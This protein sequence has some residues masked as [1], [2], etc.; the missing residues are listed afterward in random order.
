MKKEFPLRELPEVALELYAR[1]ETFRKYNVS[2]D[3]AV[4]CYNKMKTDTLPVEYELIKEEIEDI[5]HQLVHAEKT[6][7]WNSD[8]KLSAT[9]KFWVM[10]EGRVDLSWGK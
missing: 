4:T 3:S 6:L 9:T 10:F 2:L 1:E 5:D 7:N 8:G